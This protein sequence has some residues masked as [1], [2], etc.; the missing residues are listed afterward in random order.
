MGDRSQAV[1]RGLLW[2]IDNAGGGA[3][4]KTRKRSGGSKTGME[5]DQRCVAGSGAAAQTGR[6]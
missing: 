3:I 6:R 4:V 5:T 1:C 2:T